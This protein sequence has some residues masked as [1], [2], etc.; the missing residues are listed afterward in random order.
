VKRNLIL[1]KEY[2]IGTAKATRGPG[3]P[4]A[5]IL[6][7]NN[8]SGFAQFYGHPCLPSSE[9]LSFYPT[10]DFFRLSRGAYWGFREGDVPST[11]AD[12]GFLIKKSESERGLDGSVPTV[13]AENFI[14]Y[15]IDSW[16]NQHMPHGAIVTELSDLM[17][18]WYSVWVYKFFGSIT[19]PGEP[20]NDSQQAT[21]TALS[22][23]GESVTRFKL[24]RDPIAWRAGSDHV[25]LQSTD[26]K[27]TLD[28][29]MKQ[30][31]IAGGSR[32]RMQGFPE[33]PDFQGVL[34]LNNEQGDSVGAQKS[35][36]RD[37]A[38]QIWTPYLG[39]SRAA[40]QGVYIKTANIQ[41][42]YHYSNLSYEDSTIG[43]NEFA[44]P[45]IY[46]LQEA[47]D[48]PAD[49]IRFA[50]PP[51][52]TPPAPI[53][54][55]LVQAAQQAQTEI[56]YAEGLLRYR[57]QFSAIMA[58]LEDQDTS[59]DMTNRRALVQWLN[60][61]RVRPRNS[62]LRD[63]D[64]AIAG[65]YLDP[66]AQAAYAAF[67]PTTTIEGTGF[68]PAPDT[69]PWYGVITPADAAA[70]G[71]K[72]G[73]ESYDSWLF[74]AVVMR[75]FDEL[76]QLHGQRDEQL[77]TMLDDL[78]GPLGDIVDDI[79]AAFGTAAVDETATRL[80]ELQ[81]IIDA[82]IEVL[83]RADIYEQ[84]LDQELQRHGIQNA[85]MGDPL[86]LG[87]PNSTV[88]QYQ[89]A[90]TGY[91]EDIAEYNLSMD[92]YNTTVAA[93]LAS[94]S[95]ILS[96]EL[97]DMYSGLS[98]LSPAPHDTN[99]LYMP[100]NRKQLNTLPYAMPGNV[101][102]IAGATSTYISKFAARASLP[103]DA[104][105]AKRCKHIGYSQDFVENRMADYTSFGAQDRSADYTTGSTLPYGILI[106]FSTNS[107]TKAESTDLADGNF[108]AHPASL[109]LL[110][111]PG[112]ANFLL[113]NIMLA[114]IATDST[115]GPGGDAGGPT[116]ET[117]FLPNTVADIEGA[118]VYQEQYS[119]SAI[120][121]D[122]FNGKEY[123]GFE[124]VH[125][126]AGTWGTLTSEGAQSS[127]GTANFKIIDVP[128]MFTYCAQLRH[129][130][131]YYNDA[132]NPWVGQSSNDNTAL[133]FESG[134]F[135][136]NNDLN[137]FD[138]DTV[139]NS[140]TFDTACTA[141]HADVDALTI[142]TNNFKKLAISVATLIED[143]QRTFEEI[144]D[145]KL[146]YS[147]IIAFKVDKHRVGANGAPGMAVQSFYFPNVTSLD[148]LRYMDTQV[149]YG[150]QYKYKV[151]AYTLV[152]GD[153]YNY[154]NG[155]KGQHP[156]NDDREFSA[157][158]QFAAGNNFDSANVAVN[159]FPSVKIIEEPY[160]EF[161][162][163]AV[164]NV[165]P[166]SPEIQVIPFRGINNKIRFLIQRQESEY[167]IN[168]NN[169]I[170]S[171]SDID[172]YNNNRTVQGVAPN[173]PIRF[174]TESFEQESY[175]IYRVETKPLSYRDFDGKLLAIVDTKTP[176]GKKATECA[177]EDTTLVP[178]QKYYYTFRSIDPRANIS[179]P[180][181][182][183][184]V[185]LVDNN[186]MIFPLV[187]TVPVS[188]SPVDAVGKPTP[189]T[190]T[191]KPFRR[192]L[193]IDTSFPQQAVNIGAS[194]G[195]ALGLTPA[196]APPSPLL[197][198]QP[199]GVW[200]PLTTTSVGNTPKTDEK[201]FKIR[202]RS[203]QTGKKFDLNVRFVEN[204]IAN[205]IEQD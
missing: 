108:A 69:P 184:E 123:F 84:E 162:S 170:I 93:L 51:E 152:V 190:T 159:Q 43:L 167:M 156:R 145:G 168:P 2:I 89:V 95:D 119:F 36:Y 147:E 134:L 44:L 181:P 104:D 117:V 12:F 187:R 60:D 34:G 54:P 115:A 204:P 14:P 26:P 109:G 42:V 149:R 90:L 188:P 78:Q 193:Q 182:V 28:S 172:N 52:P 11:Y 144:L 32:V 13:N 110:D 105:F 130:D 179:I 63:I 131:N 53:A 163:I 135:I 151:Y 5:Q 97:Y 183:Y 157:T 178:N 56:D 82:E 86:D 100:R 153:Q 94:Q 29:S 38:H 128:G 116:F 173:K 103:V 121:E 74:E 185:E 120:K 41:T 138:G 85:I 160:C 201:V 21:V 175:E 98:C 24:W 55:S 64:D 166:T 111:I 48:H 99:P 20:L 102:A 46:I 61:S 70:Q 136:G 57:H 196:A 83:A 101:G 10:A 137:N 73:E 45:N 192:Y 31:Y 37:H 141:A 202:V 158:G 35:T 177:Y 66:E 4:A 127:A 148:R 87:Q 113:H 9:Q 6:N 77:E 118:G 114:N 203:K 27:Y 176:A 16:S 126:G 22:Y 3:L 205:P 68:P 146:A 169:F 106:D 142:T 79:A 198:T 62:T 76:E 18:N 1:D 194:N 150:Q 112:A 88:H 197:D 81:Y 96:A 165:P 71:I 19:T 155:G 191:I 139:T 23:P 7:V 25:N 58:A 107:N 132:P 164:A 67:T 186:G 161:A 15:K 122:M 195:T 143:K 189:L 154:N 75:G 72:V 91:N 92:E 174:A 199:E 17:D 124:W 8:I 171:L 140:N 200:S 40:S 59:V 30:T 50:P 129:S 125:Q 180:T 39:S 33:D 65:V 47:I 133:A 80:A 49:T